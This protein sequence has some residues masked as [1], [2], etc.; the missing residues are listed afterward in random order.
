MKE[1]RSI[2]DVERA[3]LPDDLRRVVRGTLE[4]LIEAYAERGGAYNP[5]EDGHTVLVE[6][7][8]GD[9]A[10]REAIG[11]HTLR[12]APFE[13]AAYERG[14]FVTCVLFNNQFGV[15]VVV[16]DAPW[17]DPEVRRRLTE[18]L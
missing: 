14:C 11:G 18:D 3:R 17:L 13:G 2:E 16:P 6:P 7:G 12:D 8:D 5:D 4:R 15:T 9:D 10:I 1:F